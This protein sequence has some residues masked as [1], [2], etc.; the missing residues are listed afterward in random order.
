MWSAWSEERESRVGLSIESDRNVLKAES[1]Q[2]TDLG[3]DEMIDVEEFR[4]PFHR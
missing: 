3:H 4:Q 1:F 2:Q